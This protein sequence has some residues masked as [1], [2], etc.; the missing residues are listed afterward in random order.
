VSYALPK[1]CRAVISKYFPKKYDA[2]K[3]AELRKKLQPSNWPGYPAMVPI[4][5]DPITNVCKI[6]AW[7]KSLD[8]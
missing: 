8:F 7:I 4:K 3:N 6:S 1:T 2:Q 5:N